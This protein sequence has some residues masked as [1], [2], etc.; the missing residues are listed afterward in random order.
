MRRT[1]VQFTDYAQTV[2]ASSSPRSAWL[3]RRSQYPTPELFISQRYHLIIPP[4]LP[5]EYFY[6]TSATEITTG[7]LAGDD[8]T[9]TIARAG[10]QTLVS[11]PAT[12]YQVVAWEYGAYDIDLMVLITERVT[13]QVTTNGTSG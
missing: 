5:I 12:S 9:Y 7:R 10:T 13:T 8:K 6:R 3:V 2:A 4:I 1:A 11:V